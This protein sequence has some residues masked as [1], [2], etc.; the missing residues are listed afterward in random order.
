MKNFYGILKLQYADRHKKIG[1]AKQ[2][3]II[4]LH[5]VTNVQK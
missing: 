2:I 5:F 3:D 4:L 1:M